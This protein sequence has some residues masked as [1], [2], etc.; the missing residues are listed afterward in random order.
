MNA[1]QIKQTVVAYADKVILVALVIVFGLSIYQLAL[2]RDPRVGNLKE[3]IERAAGTLRSNIERSKPPPLQRLTHARVLSERFAHIPVVEPYRRYVLYPPEPVDWR[4]FRVI[5]G[6]EAS[7][8]IHEVHL[9][10]AVEWDKDILSIKDIKPLDEDDPALGSRVII[11]PLKDTPGQPAKLVVQDIEEIRYIA[12]ILVY[13]KAPEDTPFPPNDPS[14]KVIKGR[15]LVSARVNNPRKLPPLTAK[16]E[17]F[18][19]YRKLADRP[20]DEYQLLTEKGP[21]KP[22]QS[23]RERIKKELKIDRF[24]VESPDGGY[25]G[26]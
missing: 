4:K 1:K 7:L 5:I 6:K 22:S 10:K 23:E 25:R 21:V 2:K 9:V 24:T 13:K 3:E 19:I 26:G 18:Y 12:E 14:A 8:V 11:M 16:T 15:V 20:D 17:G